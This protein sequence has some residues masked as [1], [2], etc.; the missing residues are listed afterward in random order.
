MT[1]LLIIGL[2]GVSWNVLKPMIEAGHMPFLESEIEKGKAG[3]LRST[4]P[5]I[6]P[7]AWTS[8]QT[9]LTP[10]EHGIFGFR[11]FHMENGRLRNSIRTA[12][13]VTARRIWDILS[14]K[15]R[16]ICLLNLP[17]TYPP[18]PVNGIMVSGFPVPGPECEFTYP[19]EFKRELFSVIPGFQVM[20]TGMGAMQRGMK[21]D[22]V[23]GW[24]TKLIDQKAGLARHLLKKE[25]WDV[26][27]VH[28]Q[29]TDLLQHF[30]WH[31]IDRTHPEHDPGG[32]ARVGR[33][34]NELDRRLSEITGAA[35]GKGFSVMMLSDHG[36][37][38]ADYSVNLNSWLYQKGYIVPRLS[39]R[40]LVSKAAQR[41]FELPFLLKLRGR[42]LLRKSAI[43][44]ANQFLGSGIDY[45]RSALFVESNG[46]NTAFAHF[47][48]EDEALTNKI[49]SEIKALCTEGGKPLVDSAGPISAGHPALKIIFA[50]NAVCSGMMLTNG[51]WYTRPK[52]G[53]A[54]LVGV[55]H[56]NGVV[57]FDGSVKC[58]LPRDIFEMPGLIMGCLGLQFRPLGRARGRAQ[59]PDAESSR[60]ER[61]LKGLG[62]L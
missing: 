31:L 20:Q 45:E 38:R 12:S 17:L 57:I 33:F 6:T 10:E 8:F 26:F 59:V 60:I 62:Y 28:F 2:D 15:G 37:Q 32:F 53:G 11:G 27:M 52:P 46:T 40:A 4:E 47:F 24:W 58:G 18:F 55:H 36:F 48:T 34:Y 22:D 23:V 44:M 13:S 51:H 35:R 42:L 7:T 14:K 56:V 61:Q 49:L 30:L 25:P 9:G 54:R 3:V 29:E 1:R 39:A 16:R 43:A 50:E 19:A 21:V 5:P 41:I